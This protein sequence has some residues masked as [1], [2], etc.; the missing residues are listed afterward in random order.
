MGGTLER[1]SYSGGKHW[2]GRKEGGRGR[3]SGVSCEENLS[4]N[5]SK[6][7]QSRCTPV[8]AR[9]DER[10]LHA[11]GGPFTG[12]AGETRRWRRL[13]RSKWLQTPR[14]VDNSLSLHRPTAPATVP[15]SGS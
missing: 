2:R 1:E 11:A 7:T 15:C 12:R 8:F 6:R 13:R 4:L 3:N 10:A 5:H 9:P 14:P